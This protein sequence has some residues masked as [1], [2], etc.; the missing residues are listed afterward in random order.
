MKINDIMMT[1]II[2]IVTLLYL[3][4]IEQHTLKGNEKD[5]FSEFYFSILIITMLSKGSEKV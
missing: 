1:L 4:Q 3:Y 2:N 5:C